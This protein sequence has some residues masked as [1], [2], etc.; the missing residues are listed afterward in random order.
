MRLSTSL[1]ATIFL[2]RHWTSDGL[3]RFSYKTNDSKGPEKWDKVEDKHNEWRKWENLK[4][5][6][7]ECGKTKNRQSPVDLV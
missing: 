4:A 1:L 5:K 6:D 3:E 7:N 2:A